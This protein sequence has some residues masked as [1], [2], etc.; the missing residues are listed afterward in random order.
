MDCTNGY[1][2][3]SLHPCNTVLQL[4]APGI[5]TCFLIPWI[6]ASLVT[7][8]NPQNMAEVTYA[9]STPR[10]PQ[11]L[12][13]PLSPWSWDPCGHHHM[14][15]KVTPCEGSPS[16]LMA[17]GRPRAQLSFVSLANCLPAVSLRDCPANCRCTSEPAEVSWTAPDQRV[18]PTSPQELEPD[19]WWL[20]L[21]HYLL[22]R[23]VT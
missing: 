10:F 16:Y 19:K 4:P 17:D 1:K 13:L 6:W 23:F 7:C 5:R 9:S 14:W 15:R 3:F 21:S 8:C 20:L 18:C 22:R 12:Q 11:A 2:R